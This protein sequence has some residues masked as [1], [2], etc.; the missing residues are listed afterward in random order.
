MLAETV[1]PAETT[2]ADHR[3]AVDQIHRHHL[4]VQQ[5]HQPTDRTAEAA[6]P[7][8]PAHEAAP[9]QPPDPLGNQGLQHR[10]CRLAGLQDLGE[11]KIALGGRPH[12]QGLGRHATAPGKTKGG[13]RGR[14]LGKSCGSWGTFAILAAILLPGRQAPNQNG[15][16]PRCTRHPQLLPSQPGRRQIVFNPLAQLGQS[17]PDEISGKFLAANLQ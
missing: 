12:L 10:G 13:R 15:Q 17:Q 6:L 8:S 4:V 2:A 3:I 11:D 9:L 14:A 5:G 1:A 7:R 16:A